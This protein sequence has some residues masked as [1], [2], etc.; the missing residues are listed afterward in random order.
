[1]GDAEAGDCGGV[2]VAILERR[3]DA[4][5]R[6]ALSVDLADDPLWRFEPRA[7]LEQRGRRPVRFADLQLADLRHAAED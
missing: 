4:V 5:P 1:V 3:D 6:G 7:K 2:L